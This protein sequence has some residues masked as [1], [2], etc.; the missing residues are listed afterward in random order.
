MEEILA[1]GIA[2]AGSVV[3]RGEFVLRP[4]NRHSEPIHE[5]LAGASINLASTGASL[6]VEIQAD[7]LER[8]VFIEGEVPVP[9]F[10][11]WSQS[12]ED[13]GVEFSSC[14]GS[15][16]RHRRFPSRTA[17]GATSWPSRRRRDG[18]TTMFAWRTSSSETGSLSACSISTSPL[19]GDHLRPRFLCPDVRTDRR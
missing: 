7:G 17:P 13:V 14:V 1:G 6:P 8:L 2:N 4:S 12:D 16:R 3:R 10:P 9:P 15:T 19:Q 11:E 5:V 18:V